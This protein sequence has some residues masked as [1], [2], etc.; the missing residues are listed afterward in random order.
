MLLVPQNSEADSLKY[1]VNAAVPEDLVL[2]LFTNNVT[3]AE[4]DTAANYT[5]ASG[6]G[7]AAIALLGASWAAP[8]EGLP[9]SIAYPQQTFLFTG[10]LGAV[11]GYFMT[12]AISARIALAERFTDGPYTVANAGDA[13]KLT[14]RLT[15]D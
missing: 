2:R 13:I 12:R 3:P 9:S 14:P 1:F 6:S 15:A 10:A 11:Y 8:V 4:T 7:Y 5:E